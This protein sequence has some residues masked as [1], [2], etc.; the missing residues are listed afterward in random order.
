MKKIPVYEFQ[1]RIDN[2]RE[3]MKE[4]DTDIFLIYGDEYRRENLRYL[5]NYWPIF[6]RGLLVVGNE[7]EPILLVSPEC[8]NL[9]K[10]MSVWKDIRMVKD[11]GMSYVPDEVDFKNT[12]FSNIKE[13]INEFRNE[14]KKLKVKISGMDAM[15]VILYERI[16]YEI[17]NALI[18]NG[19]HVLYKLRYIKSSI[20]I[21]ILKEAWRICDI[22]YKAVLDSEIIG[23][24]ERQAAA[25]G[26]KA[27]Y[28]AGAES[29]VFSIFASGERTNSVVGR[30]SEKIIRKNDMIMY[31]LAVQF[32]G[33][34]ASN[35]WPF[36]AGNKPNK[37]QDML[38]YN[39]IKA[40]D[41]G[42][43][44]INQAVSQ[45]DIVKII[46]NYFI[47]NGYAKNDLYPPMHGNGLSEAE[48]PYPDE[49][50]K[51]KFLPGIGFNFDVSLFGVKDIGSNRIEEGFFV[52]KDGIKPLSKLISNLRKSYL[53]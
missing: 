36:V 29:I 51:D 48:P 25:I 42:I 45:G 4:D 41:I 50:S 34:I 27:S 21:E 31:A 16:K 32:E 1:N 40:E 20:E 33:Y 3:I 47:K 11:V 46:R 28:D 22:G 19:D 13:I 17:D 39:L 24:T 15:S 9:S 12:K 30:P 7:K 35:E 26:E 2:L 5:S 10:E 37:G 44:S 43:N 6:E 49:N 38:I 8:E 53:N 18:E 52:Q 14:S 23:L